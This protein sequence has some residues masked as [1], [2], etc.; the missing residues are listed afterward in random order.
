VSLER[1]GRPFHQAIDSDSEADTT[2]REP[3]DGATPSS[4]RPARSTSPNPSRAGRNPRRTVAAS[5]EPHVGPRA[6]D[7]VVQ[8]TLEWTIRDGYRWQERTPGRTLAEVIEHRERSEPEPAA[9]VRVLRPADP[10]RRA[11]PDPVLLE[12]VQIDGSGSP[13]ARVPAGDQP[14]D[15]PAARA[16]PA[17]RDGVARPNFAR[18]T[19]STPPNCRRSSLC[20]RPPTRGADGGVG[21]HRK[22]PSRPLSP[23]NVDP[24]HLGRAGPAPVHPLIPEGCGQQEGDR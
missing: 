11:R 20:F 2:P 4:G 18:C 22:R 8:D 1:P 5:L 16:R 12:R 7:R 21:F 19:E 3:Y 9:D 24:V 6:S 13:A 10:D 23:T 14:H 15:G 17:R